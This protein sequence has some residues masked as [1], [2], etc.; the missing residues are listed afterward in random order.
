MNEIESTKET[1]GEPLIEPIKETP[2]SPETPKE[3][4]IKK[5]YNIF[6]L[7]QNLFVGTSIVLTLILAIQASVLVIDPCENTHFSNV[8]SK[9]IQLVILINFFTSILFIIIGGILYLLNKTNKTK[10]AYGKKFLLRGVIGLILT[11]IIY[12]A[13]SVIAGMIGICLHGSSLPSLE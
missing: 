9:T 6:G 7:I 12:F 13:I 1:A 4:T 10:N 11:F 8:M 3:P 5:I 2:K